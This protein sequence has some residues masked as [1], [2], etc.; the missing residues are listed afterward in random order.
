[1]IKKVSSNKKTGQMLITIPKDNKEGI[2]N[3]DW[4]E[5]KKVDNRCKECGKKKFHDNAY[6]D[7]CYGK[8]GA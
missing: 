3:D 2:A 1:M 5:I 4:I 7:R 8:L 6:C